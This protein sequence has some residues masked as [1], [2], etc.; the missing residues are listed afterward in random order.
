[1]CFSS[2]QISL[3]ILKY[4]S[5]LNVLSAFSFL[6][7]FI[8]DQTLVA[9]LCLLPLKRALDR[10]AEHS[11]GFCTFLPS[12]LYLLPLLYLIPIYYYSCPVCLLVIRGS[13][14]SQ[15]SKKLFCPLAMIIQPLPSTIIVQPVLTRVAQQRPPYR[16]CLTL[17][18]RR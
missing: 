15:H 14:V 3:Q 18:D 12:P 16:D 1:M 2:Y 10:S 8:G 9:V 4:C 17:L 13:N 7:A 6:A 11:L 5:F